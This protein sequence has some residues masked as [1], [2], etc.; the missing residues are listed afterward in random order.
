MMKWGDALLEACAL[1][2]RY[3]SALIFI[4]VF[5]VLAAVIGAQFGLSDLASWTTRIPLFGNH[6]NMTSIGELQW[7]VF[8]LIVMLSGAYALKE[9]RHVRVDVLSVRFSSRTRIIVDILGD[10][11][12]LIPFF[13]LLAWYSWGFMLMAYGFGEQSNAGGLVD[14]YLVKAVLPIGSVLILGAGIGRVLRN[15]GLLLSA[16][17]GNAAIKGTPQ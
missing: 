2:G 10:A 1:P 13:A 11:F 6:L 12:F 17:N 14:R 8:S 7:H 9:D 16:G 4:L 3:G 15:V 5:V